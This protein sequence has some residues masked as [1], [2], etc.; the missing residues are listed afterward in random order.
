MLAFTLTDGLSTVLICGIVFLSATVRSTIG[1]GEALIAM[2]LL[3]TLLPL[4]Q[5][6]PLVAMLSFLNGIGIL[7]REWQHIRFRDALSFTLPAIL[8][9]P[10]GVW[11]LQSGDDRI[12]KSLLAVVIFIFS[13]WSLIHP[14]GFR[15]KDDRWG[16]VV[17][18]IAGFLGGAYN[19]SGP[20]VVM[21]G[22]LRRWPPER[23]RAM[24]QSF[25]TVTSI[26]VLTMHFVSGSV[27]TTVLHYFVT[28]LPMVALAIWTGHRL[29]KL[30]SPSH[31]ARIVHL[32]L[33]LIAVFLLLNVAFS[34]ASTSA[35]SEVQKAESV[36]RVAAPSWNRFC[37]PSEHQRMPAG[38]RHCDRFSEGTGSVSCRT[39]GTRTTG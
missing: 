28:S 39:S 15:L 23:F 4:Q 20:P 3:G 21:Y 24:L 17:G 5:A 11:L 18:L 12:A 26:W 25:F 31:F 1:F 16:P 27:T 36:K 30:I 32:V 6:A 22:A 19:T 35:P 37:L 38:A 8:T 9:V 14:D 34:F 7:I 2:P 29:A 10:L 13:M 33:I